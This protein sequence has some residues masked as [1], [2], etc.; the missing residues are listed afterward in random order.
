MPSY[1][2]TRFS[3]PAPV[4]QV[5]LRRLDKT[6]AVEDVPLLL[7]TGADVTML[8]TTAVARLGEVAASETTF[9]LTG[10]DGQAVKPMRFVWSCSCSDVPFVVSFC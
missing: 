9:E 7:D 5:T 3:P 1:D 2:G 6:A 4:A 8:P 10:F